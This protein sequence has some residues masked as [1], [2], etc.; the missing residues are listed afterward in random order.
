MK[1]QERDK[2]LS[3]EELI[4]TLNNFEES[5]DFASCEIFLSESAENGNPDALALIG[6]MYLHQDIYDI[7]KA[8]SWTLQA[9]QSGSTLGMYNYGI[10]LREE[11]ESNPHALIW[12]E[13]AA[14]SGDVNAY[15]DLAEIYERFNAQKAIEYYKFALSLDQLF[16]SFKIGSLYQK[17]GETIKS[18]V[19][20]NKAAD[21]G[22]L[23][24]ITV[25]AKDCELS[26]D[27]KGARA[28]HEKLLELEFETSKNIN[29]DLSENHLN[30][31]TLRLIR[32]PRE[33]EE[34]AAEWMRY[35]GFLDASVTPVGPDQGIDVDSSEAVAQVKMEGISTSRPTIQGIAGVAALE[36]KKAFF[37]SLGGF[38]SEAIDW[39]E[40]ANVF[41][42]QFDLQGEPRAI[43]SHARKIIQ[44]TDN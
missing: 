23:D 31:P 27:L 17:L 40:K 9:A 32:T 12:L 19:W 34:V 42:F 5:G 11:D 18:Q 21:L 1:E 15:L 6:S 38:T 24:A 20:L 28:W 10:L 36:N 4:S 16:I 39:S 13:K 44:E 35:L 37:F 3:L 7:E 33:A 2:K 22:S 43:N 25:L 29:L 30:K 41:L 26:G 8:K 14:Q